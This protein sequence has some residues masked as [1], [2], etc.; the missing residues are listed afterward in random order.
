MNEVLRCEGCHAPMAYGGVSTHER[1]CPVLDNRETPP[2]KM[3]PAQA[4]GVLNKW[5]HQNRSDWAVD[6]RV[7]R[8]RIVPVAERQ[9]EH[10]FEI[11]A[12]AEKYERESK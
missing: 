11:V 7:G 9:S 3:T 10:E 4:V 2:E 5:C 8:T 12:M 1:N 6:C